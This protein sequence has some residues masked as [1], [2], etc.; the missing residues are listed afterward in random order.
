VT[1][2]YRAYV[3][4]LVGW[5]ED[6]H[7]QVCMIHLCMDV[8]DVCLYICVCLKRFPNYFNVLRPC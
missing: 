4:D 1:L 8:V 6:F 2:E 3:G 5:E 7:T